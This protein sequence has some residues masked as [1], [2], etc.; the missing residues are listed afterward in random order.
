MTAATDAKNSRRVVRYETLADL[1]QDVET[2]SAGEYVTV[3]QWSFAQILHHIA[4]S[5]HGS[6]DGMPFKA[7]WFIR[8]GA[9]F[10]KNSILTKQMKPGFKL[11]KSAADLLPDPEITLDDAK[12]RVLDG[13]K[14]LETEA[15]T[16]AHPVFG[17]IATEEW[18]SLHL[19]HS[20]LHMSFVIPVDADDNGHGDSSA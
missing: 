20:E 8:L 12:S 9:P 4:M 3:G 19:R 7:P 17:K 18:M 11:P 1:R 14:R 2:L 13:I 15:P 5:L 10:I 16:A 6:I